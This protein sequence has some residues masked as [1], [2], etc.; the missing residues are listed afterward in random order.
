[1]SR[2]VRAVLPAVAIG[3]A[4]ANAGASQTSYANHERHLVAETPDTMIGNHSAR[5]VGATSDADTMA[6]LAVIASLANEASAG[7]AERAIID[8]AN[9]PTV[10]IEIRSE[11]ALAARALSPSDTTMAGVDKAESAGILT[12]VAVLGPLRDTG[13]GLDAHDGPERT[14]DPTGAAGVTDAATFTNM[15]TSYSWGTV[16]VEWRAVPHVFSQARG[17]PLDLFVHPRRESCS[18]VASKI[19]LDAA[20][21]IIVRLAAAGQARLAFDGVDVAKSDDVDAQGQ[22]DR[23]AARIDAKAGSHIVY[24][25][26]C[27]GAL[28]DSGRVRL[29]ITDTNYAPLRVTQSADLTL[30]DGETIPWGNANAANAKTLT[31]PLERAIDP[32][33]TTKVG[34]ANALLD[35]A[36][37]RIMAGADDLKSPRAAGELDAFLQNPQNPNL[38]A[39]PAD[40]VAM[41]AILSPSGATKSARLSWA[42]KVAAKDND[43]VTMA[44]VDRR[45]AELR[46]DTNM[47][48]WAFATLRGAG[49]DKQKDSEALV[50]GARALRD[51]DVNTLDIQAF[52]DVAAAFRAAPKQVSNALVFELARFART[53]DSNAWV[54]ATS[55]LARRGVGSKAFV[56][57]MGTRGK[58]EVVKAAAIGFAGG[59][60]DAHEALSIAKNVSEAGAHDVALRLYG[61]LVGWAPNRAE[62]WAGLARELSAAP[63]SGTGKSDE[64]SQRAILS[65]L[66]RVRELK[67]SDANVRAELTMRRGADNTDK[68]SNKPEDDER[69]LTPTSTILARRKGIAKGNAPPDVV[70]RQLHWLRAV[71]THADHRISQ[72]IQYAREV[73]IAPRTQQELVEPIPQEGDLTEILRARLY[74]KDGRV[75]FP[76]EQG[77]ASIRWPEIEP[78]DTVEVVL[79]QWTAAAVGGRGDVPFYFVDYAGASASHP[80][81]YNHVVV[82]TLPFR[83]LFID[84]LHSELGSPK[85]MD[86]D[87]RGMHVT[88]LIWDNPV[89]VAEEPLAPELTE[90]TP[91]V[92][93][94][95]FQ[96]WA[97][98]RKWYAE[99]T[100]DFTVPDDEVRRIA[101]EITKGKV[102]RDDKLR[103]IF[104]FVS[105]DIRYVNFV[106]GEAW[107]PNRPQELLARRQ[108]DCDDKA[109]LLITLLRAIGIEAEEVLVQTR[110]TGQPS[111]FFA[112]NAAIPL[113]DHGIAL[114]PGP[115]GGMYLDAT[116]PQ[117]RI[118]PIPSMD[119]RAFAL[120][121][122]GPAE[123]VALAESSPSE[124]GLDVTWTLTLAADGSG[125][126]VGE[127]LHSGDSAFELRTNLSQAAARAQYVEDEIL[128]R[129]FS[130][131]DLDKAIDFQGDLKGGRAKVTYKAKSRNVTRR[132]GED[133]VLSLSSRNTL[134]SFLAPLKVRTLPTVLP[135][136]LAPSHHDR[137]MR[138]VAPAGFAWGELPSG[139]DANGPLGS[140]FG[141]AHL[142]IVL[143]TSNA[144][145]AKSGRA[146]VIK[147]SVAFNQHLIAVSEY[148]S[149]REWL[150]QVDALLHKEVRLVRTEEAK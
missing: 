25:K 144:S 8:I 26:V 7:V 78:G 29:R 35:A 111:L 128:G 108:G 4:T 88:E 84:V 64:S 92:V 89:S 75:V 147:R 11:A 27:S 97:D 10:P 67:P 150:Q 95:T 149:W 100:R 66:E 110:H 103:A 116:S 125:E 73:V 140:S 12:S 74:K 19:H 20:K 72:L 37:V 145:N 133:L 129:W 40:A 142:E 47:T 16:K 86:R 63:Q 132:E 102:S 139:G 22:F 41:A 52:R 50:L 18:L 104:N 81:L 48:D 126:L 60:S 138:I 87:E 1:M 39:L 131:I 49:I 69:W 119:A 13:G 3:I 107:L 58:D 24:A 114:L 76:L 146:L 34:S 113:F 59:I 2:V 115:G 23:L 123:I 5:A 30:H 93:G 65:A 56:D 137:T 51:L 94:S 135:S 106:S 91:V 6:S 141:H 112:K 53:N 46:L 21:S 98:F 90:T 105:D 101:R 70:D 118:G 134:I 32:A 62:A 44:F 15:H 117:S 130:A 120:R 14:P 82:E 96:S 143:D 124:H 79:R 57:A 109:I 71:R 83:P 68:Q 127:E 122:K 33:I 55:E 31:T 28:G 85:R 42:R 36:I 121:M 77:D 17:T 99:A 136:T 148:A 61:T 80:L 45:L 38:P 43:T 9:A 54:E